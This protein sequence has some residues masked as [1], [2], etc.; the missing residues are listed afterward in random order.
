MKNYTAKQ[1]RDMPT[2]ELVKIV[3]EMEW[4]RRDFTDKILQLDEP[5]NLM[6]KLYEIKG[7]T[8]TVVGTYTGMEEAIAAAIK[9]LKTHKKHG[10]I[11]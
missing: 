1:L 3:H 6:V 2:P 11:F 8:E 5:H 7:N 10:F 4:E 9:F